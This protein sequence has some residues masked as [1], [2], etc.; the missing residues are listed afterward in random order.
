MTVSNEFALNL[1]LND[2]IAESY[3][4]LQTIGDGESISGGLFT[5]AQKSLNIMLKLWE[6]Q[7]IHLWTMTEGSLFL[8]IGRAKNDFRNEGF[9]QWRQV[10][11]AA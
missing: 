2:V 5:R 1:T 10:T 8:K 9:E 3:E 7:G 6:T 11:A 4:L